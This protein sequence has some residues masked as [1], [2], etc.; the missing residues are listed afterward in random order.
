M[1]FISLKLFVAFYNDLAKCYFKALIS[2][3]QLP[4]LTFIK[5]VSFDIVSL[6]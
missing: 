4:A 2:H 3:D 6:I 5:S 1:N